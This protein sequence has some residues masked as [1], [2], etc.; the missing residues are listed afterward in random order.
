MFK[1]TINYM[2]KTK[3]VLVHNNFKNDPITDLLIPEDF[4]DAISTAGG[5]TTGDFRVSLFWSN[6]DD[7]DLY[8]IEPSGNKVFYG[9]KTSSIGGVLDVDANASSTTNRPIENIVYDKK[10]TLANGTYKVQVDQ[11]NKRSSNNDGFLL[12]VVLDNVEYIYSYS[13]SFTGRNTDMVIITYFNNMFTISS[14]NP[15]L[16]LRV[17]E[18]KPDEVV[19]ESS[20]QIDSSSVVLTTPLEVIEQKKK[21]RGVDLYKGET[22]V[23]LAL[24]EYGLESTLENI[25]N[26]QYSLNSKVNDI[27]ELVRTRIIELRSKLDD[28]R[29]NVQQ[30][31][32]SEKKLIGE[33]YTVVVPI[34]KDYVT[35]Q[36]TA[37]ISDGV[38]LG[39]G[40]DTGKVIQTALELDT[41]NIISEENTKFKISGKSN[42]YPLTLSVNKNLYNPYNQFR[43]ILP[44]IT[45]SGILLIKFD[46]VEAISILNK[47]GYE[48][49][50]KHINNTIK[51]PVDSSSKSFSIR[52]LDSSKRDIQI[53]A[54]YFTEAIYNKE[55]IYETFPID[56]NKQLSYLTVESCDNY[57][58]KDVDIKYEISI[59]GEEYEE[60]R[61][62]GKLK[63]NLVQSIIK[64]DKYGY[65][66]PIVLENAVRNEGVFKFYPDNPIAQSSKLK[67]FSLKLGT[68]ILSLES[69]L[70]PKGVVG[71]IMH[72]SYD[73]DLFLKYEGSRFD[74]IYSE[75][76]EE[77][78]KLPL[79][80][81]EAFTFYI[82]K[83]S[84]I[85]L[86]GIKYN[87]DDTI[88]GEVHLSKGLHTI[89]FNREEWKELVDLTLYE[90]VG[91]DTDFIEVSNRETGVKEKVEYYFNPK[92]KQF[93]SYYLQLWLQKVDI[94]LF[95]D[96]V[97]RKYDN[98]YLEYFY[99][100]NPYKTYIL[101]ESPSRL[102]D[103]IQIR[104]TMKSINEVVCPYISK[105]IVRGI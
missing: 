27:N 98:S 13:L 104:A 90:L 51:F 56:I 6:S 72:E 101:N 28:C 12:R 77:M 69:F 61:P 8:V 57:A 36:T 96:T 42:E 71:F 67:A 34:V 59:N 95:E 63:E 74:L 22:L 41:V 30:A 3:E 5:S 18:T 88:D 52:F 84:Y 78:I 32:L 14:A 29:S 94:Y 40:Y 11:Y 70:E 15:L 1:S 7:L 21:E 45:Q 33:T 92:E 10:S 66:E 102:V 91:I 75:G 39:V 81:K 79:V 62:S 47:D 86:D 68:D 44:T 99:K 37:T 9:S 73:E 58:T 50:S 19:P 85:I 54:M 35:P 24:Q 49:V 26:L 103:T 105:I 16:K 93:N 25:E 87:Y 48:I 4:D 83:D 23:D 82:N 100:D 20:K 89:E 97:K 38:I 53:N 2:F 80:V 55:T 60:Y 64:T 76:V 46:K 31:L 65:N 43:I 17:K